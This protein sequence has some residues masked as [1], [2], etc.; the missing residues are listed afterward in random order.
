MTDSSRNFDMNQL[1][2]ISNDLVNV[3]QDPNDR[4]LNILSQCLQHTLSLSSTCQSDLNQVSSLF[5]DYQNKIDSHNQKIKDARSETAADAEL[6]LLQRELDEELEKERLLKEEFRAI[7]NEFN[8]LEQ[9]QISVR[10]QKKKLLKIVQEKQRTRMLLSM[11]A[12]VT[13]IVP[14]LDD[15]SKISGYIVEKEKHAVEKFE[16]DTLQMTTLDVCN[17]MWK[18][19]SN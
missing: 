15:Q 18:T 9:Q 17:D 1:I 11:Y 2:S 14:N 6:E 4:D 7:G 16:F 19:I 12:S 5:Q 3:L 13:N 8:D 10:E